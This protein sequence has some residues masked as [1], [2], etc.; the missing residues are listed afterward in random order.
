MILFVHAIAA[1]L[2]SG[3]LFNYLLGPGWWAFFI[4]IGAA[5]TW[6]FFWYLGADFLRALVWRVLP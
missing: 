4:S 5:I 6:T 2:I 3:T 1:G